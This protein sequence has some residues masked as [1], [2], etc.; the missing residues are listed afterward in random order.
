MAAP[1]DAL[2]AVAAPAVPQHQWR[3]Q[4]WSCGAATS[5]QE[6]R[7]SGTLSHMVQRYPAGRIEPFWA[8]Q[9]FL[10]QANLCAILSVTH[11]AGHQAE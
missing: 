9:A 4:V 6:G 7:G 11:P 10:L 3:V 1:I 2:Q 5:E 8:L